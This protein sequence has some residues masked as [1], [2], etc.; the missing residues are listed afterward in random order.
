MIA[1]QNSTE[2]VLSS[3]TGFITPIPIS[4]RVPANKVIALDQSIVLACFLKT[5]DKASM[6]TQIPIIKNITLNIKHI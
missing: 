2:P 3:P 4:N 5:K 6:M 1:P